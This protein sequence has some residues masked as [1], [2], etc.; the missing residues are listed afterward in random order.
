M[1]IKVLLLLSMGHFTADLCQGGLPLFLPYL[2]EEFNLSYFM[3]GIIVLTA[4]ISSSVIQPLFGY[5]GDRWENKWFL[6]AGCLLATLGLA[7]IGV[8][9]NFAMVLLAVLISGLGNAAY[10]PEAS[11]AAHF[12]SGNR[13]ASAMAVF[14]VGGNI[15]FAAGPVLA[16]FLMGY[17]G[18]R[19]SLGFI[20]P[21][22]IAILL[23]SKN[24]SSIFPGNNQG[25]AERPKGLNP[26]QVNENESKL[27]DRHGALIILIGVVAV[28]SWIYHGL[29][30]YIPLFYVSYLKGD[31]AY[32]TTV[33]TVFLASGV[34]GT[35]IGGPIADIWGRKSLIILSMACSIP[36]LYL[37]QRTSV[38]WTIVIAAL[39]GVV[40]VS[41]F[42]VTIVFAQELMPSRLGLASGLILGLA[43][44]MGG[45]GVIIL[46]Y[47]S[48]HWGVP[49]A[50]SVIGLLP[51]IG[52]SLAAFLPGYKKMTATS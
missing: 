16:G 6:P 45:T 10:H 26:V 3:V 14:S 49:A 18:L 30:S 38:L 9:Q 22:L 13:R 31:P 25:A 24:L 1:N 48:D 21:G 33:L 52:L 12:H 32:A 39:L 23:L 47:I 41:S 27:K 40:V 7:L 50:L 35:I 29:I 17:A 28:R 8:S 5:F 46:G 43:F 34:I 44:G 36:M 37:F 19:G 15:G 42:A 2:K 11:K 4:Y 20:L 51:V